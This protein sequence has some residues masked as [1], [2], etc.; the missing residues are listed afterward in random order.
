MHLPLACR[1][2]FP[3]C[4][5]AGRSINNALLQDD[6]S[7]EFAGPLL[8]CRLAAD[9]LWFA[10]LCGYHNITDVQRQALLSRLLKLT[11]NMK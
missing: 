4:A 9:G 8:L 1:Y 10:T 11:E 3:A 6:A 5:I 2:H 7:P